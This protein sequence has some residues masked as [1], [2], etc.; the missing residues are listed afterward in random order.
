LKLRGFRIET[1][2]VEAA[3]ARHPEVQSCAVAARRDATGQGLLVAYVVAA[4]PLAAAPAVPAAAPPLPAPPGSAAFAALAGRLRAFLQGSLPEP[5]VPSRFVEVPALPRNPSGKLDRRALPDPE[6][7]AR[8]R[9]APPRSDL[10]RF[11]AA[12]WSEVLGVS[13]IGVDD[14]FFQLGGH[15]LSGATL[16]GRLQQELGEIVHV[17]AMYDAPTVGRLAVY[18]AE[19][20][21]QAVRRLTLPAPVPDTRKD[22]AP[23][24]AASA[25]PPALA[26]PAPAPPVTTAPALAG[27]APTPPVT[28]APAPAALA[29]LAPQPRPEPAS[30]SAP[31]GAA[32]LAELRRIVAGGRVPR[33]APRNP[34][35][36]FVL[37]PPRSGSTL[38]RVMLAGHPLLFAPPELE[39][40]SFETLAERRAAFAG[41]NGFWLEGAVRA[42]MEIHRC[43][44]ARAEELLAAMEGENATSQE[45]YRRMQEW[46]APRLL[47]DK[48][49]S[50]AL[51]P[52]VLARAERLFDGARY[53]HLLRHPL[54]MIRSFEE[55]RLDQVFFR[56]PHGF[57]RRQLA[58]L[59]WAA[60]EESILAFLAGVPPERQLALRFEDLVARPEEDLRRLCGWLG[61]EFD[62]AMAQPYEEKAARMTDGIHPWSRMLGDIKFHQHRGVDASTADHWRA[63]MEGHLLGRPAAELAARL[64]YDCP[65]PASAPS[66][67]PAAF[68]PPA[69]PPS[70]IHAACPPS[71]SEPS[72]I[73]V[74]CPQAARPPSSIPPP[75]ARSSTSPAVP[76]SSVRSRHPALV[77]LQ[78][79]GS[80]PPLVCVH[81]AG[82]DV[83][84]YRELALALGGNR[85]VYG[86]EAQGIRAGEIP[87]TRMEE[88][89]ERSL[90][91]L[92]TVVPSGPYN[93]LG[94]SFGG[95]VA[96]EIACRLAAAGRAVALLAILDAAPEAAAAQPLDEAD[97]LAFGFESVLPVSAAEIRALP[98]GQRLPLL[99]ARAGAAGKLPPGLDHAHAH[100]LLA[101]F[102]A[103]Q[104]AARAYRP[105]HYPGR[106][107]LIR[108]AG[109]AVPSGGESAATEAAGAA[110]PSHG[111]ATA[112]SPVQPPGSARREP[113]LGWNR[114]AAAVEVHEV[115]GQHENMVAPP[116]V[117]ALADCLRG[118]LAA[119]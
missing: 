116:H 78:A 79:R 14:D 91:A 21:P 15:S 46:V 28:A 56:F 106:L 80:L 12:L 86:L 62:R 113:T 70:T 7:F 2:E 52:E 109:P 13:G 115:P 90:A 58:E 65:V 83:L 49:P 6:A 47:V 74:A 85:P 20:Y 110:A 81:P 53:I 8:R 111:S 95:L 119:R 41:R 33:A 112:P 63:A 102:Q 36:L 57:S 39:L 35:A 61:L 87:L 1:G 24:A 5:M 26:G 93:L 97:L 55:A 29:T 88:I 3:L 101:V 59:I 17:V 107:T 60:S 114:L 96:Y 99:L 43:D 98:A 23:V 16:V 73:P 72:T 84:C 67:V 69:N 34:P 40:L 44:A 108:A 75:E 117:A 22:T 105:A 31:A 100:R 30:S 76:P 9:S 25:P 19:H 68:A 64:G 42:V 104:L 51:D 4:R 11:L 38:L 89:A 82:G 10:E 32:E 54:A 66:T 27:P 118:L 92:L 50:Y 71:A 18:L 103:N 94:W 45:L 77:P 37:S 48:T